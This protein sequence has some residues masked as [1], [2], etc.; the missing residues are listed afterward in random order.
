MKPPQKML[1]E[2]SNVMNDIAVQCMT[3]EDVLWFDD[4]MQ[5]NGIEYHIDGGWAVDALLGEQTREHEDLD[6]A[7][8]ETYTTLLCKLLEKEGFSEQVRADTWE[9]N[10]RLT[11]GVQLFDIHTYTLN[12]DGSNRSGVAYEASHFGGKGKIDGREVPCINPQTLV[13][14]HTGY[15]VDENDWHDVKLLCARYT[16]PIPKDYVKFQ[17]EAYE[18]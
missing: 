13:E 3:T 14:F 10:Y 4:L 1:L 2:T 16:I 7:M 6:I 12:P 5:A 11:D 17:K 18:S 15:S 9:C 8:P